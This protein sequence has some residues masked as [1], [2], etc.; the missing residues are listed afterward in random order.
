MPRRFPWTVLVFVVAAALVAPALHLRPT[1]ANPLVI[2]AMLALL[3]VVHEAGHLIAALA[4]RHRIFEVRIGIG[5]ALRI[6]I[7]RSR[8]IVAAI[9]IGGHVAAATP[10]AQGYRWRRLIV[11]AAGSLMNATVLLVAVVA[12][13][14]PGSLLYDLAVLDGIVLVGNLVPYSGASAFGPQPTDGL[15]LLRT[16]VLSE[17]ELDEAL[18][19]Y[20]VS[21]AKRLV[22]QGD[23]P[24]ARAEINRG[25]GLH[26]ESTG[27]R[28][29]LGHDLVVSGRYAEAR[30]VF[31]Q[32]VD[33]GP[34][35]RGTTGRLLHA[36]HLNN[37]AWADL[38]IGDR[39][40]Y[41]EAEMASRAAIEELPRLPAIRGTRALALIESGRVREGLELSGS[42][43]RSEK[44]ARNRALQAC[45]TAIGC[46]RD[47]RFA[48]AQRWLDK[49]RHLD[50]QCDLLDRAS[51]EI[52]GRLPRPIPD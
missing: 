4:V 11:V 39:T 41:P 6:P 37:L 35:H 8:L 22:D 20:Y 18:A 48:D 25:L 5:P 7:G 3:T 38:M 47:W 42:A 52:A 27:L 36:L 2:L 30:A 13:A 17:R 44:D 50:P 9:P 24:A 33:E 43:L 31:A 19:A 26:P 34:R 14:S 21:E 1:R 12:H 16:L 15:S 10:D 29:W 46:A 28:T 23:R 51:H 32:L 49:A 45:V 40:L